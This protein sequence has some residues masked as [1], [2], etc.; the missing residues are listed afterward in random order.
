MLVKSIVTAAVIAVVL[1]AI[2]RGIRAADWVLMRQ[3][4]GSEWQQRGPAL[5]QQAACLTA[6]ASDG[7]VVPA[8]TRLKCE[9]KESAK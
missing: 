8:G 6:L 5:D 2:A 4:P 1:I 9:K 7:F 3:L